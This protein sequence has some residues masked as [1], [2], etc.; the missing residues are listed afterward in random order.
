MVN[1]QKAARQLK[2]VLMFIILVLAV[3]QSSVFVGKAGWWG[4]V[5]MLA[6]FTALTYV[7]FHLAFT[8]YEPN[9]MMD[10]ILFSALLSTIALLVSPLVT[11]GTVMMRV[12]MILIAR[13][14][15]SRGKV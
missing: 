8:K 1:K 4:M 12:V 6:Y 7:D 2:G 9:A 10:H 3:M 13:L 11:L 14:A 5:V 15:V